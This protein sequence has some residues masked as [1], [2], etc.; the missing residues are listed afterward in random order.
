MDI[1]QLHYF[2]VLCEEMKYNRCGASGLL[3][4]A[5]SLGLWHNLQDRKYSEL[6]PAKRVRRAVDKLRKAAKNLKINEVAVA[7]DAT[8]KIWTTTTDS[9]L[10]KSDTDA[11]F[12]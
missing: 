11:D 8:L 9:Y 5:V 4:P 2:L 10:Q 7:S 3:L 1:R 12:P 6:R